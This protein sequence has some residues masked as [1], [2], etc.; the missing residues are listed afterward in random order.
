[1]A[2]LSD[3]AGQRLLEQLM[4]LFVYPEIARRQKAG[5]I[6][7]PLNR[8][9]AQILFFPDGKKPL[10]RINSEIKAIGKVK[11]GKAVSKET[12]DPIREDEVENLDEINRPEEDYPDCGHATLIRIRERWTIAFDFRVNKPLARKHVAA[13]HEFLR[14][15]ERCL[16][17]EEWHPFFDNLFSAA[18]LSVRSI[19]LTMQDKTQT[20]K[21]VSIRFNRFADLGNVAPEH[22]KTFNRLYGA[23]DLARYLKGDITI[24]R[25]EALTML[26]DVKGLIRRASILVG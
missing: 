2:Q 11:L 4:N 21:G 24:T 3:E 20:H 19:L 15:A 17:R 13:A 12:G 9:A 25:E 23:R 14:S 1:M 16:K 26:R 6:E 8:W 10:V 18:E 5:E 22:K 7:K